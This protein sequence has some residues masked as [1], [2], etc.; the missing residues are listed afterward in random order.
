MKECICLF[1]APK[2]FWS[3]FIAWLKEKKKQY[4]GQG[5]SH[6]AVFGQGSNALWNKVELGTQIRI[7]RGEKWCSQ[8][9]CPYVQVSCK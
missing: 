7:A 3:R 2:V 6:P 5:Y 9:E 4:W 8:I 1:I